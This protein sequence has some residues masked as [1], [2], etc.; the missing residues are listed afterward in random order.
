MG[1][2]SIRLNAGKP[3]LTIRVALKLASKI[4][5]G[6]FKYIFTDRCPRVSTMEG[7]LLQK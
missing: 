5:L 2:A 7:W 4:A 1:G 6:L 3:V